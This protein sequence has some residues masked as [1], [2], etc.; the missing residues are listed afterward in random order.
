MGLGAGGLAAWD[1]NLMCWYCIALVLQILTMQGRVLLG[2]GQRQ[3]A[4]NWPAF[5][6]LAA[7][8][9]GSNMSS[10]AA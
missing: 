10:T 4:H 8:T 9:H 5:A 3:L 1:K 7:G 2:P 6:Y